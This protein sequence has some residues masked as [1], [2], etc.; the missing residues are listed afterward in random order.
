[1]PLLPEIMRRFSESPEQAASRLGLFLGIY[2]LMQFFAAPFFGA[3]SDIFGRRPILLL[4]SLGACL[5]YILQ[6]MSGEFWFL[7]LGR[8]VAGLTS[9]KMPLACSYLV[10][11]SRAEDRAAH[12]GGLGAAAAAGFTS[13]TFLAAWFGSWNVMA[14]F[15]AGA[16]VNLLTCGFIWFAMPESLSVKKPAAASISWSSLYPLGSLVKI[17]KPSPWSVFIWIYLLVLVVYQVVPANWALATQAKVGWS[18]QD[19]G[20]SLTILGATFALGQGLLPRLAMPRLGENRSLILGLGFLGISLTLVGFAS[21]SWMLY[22]SILIFSCSAHLIPTLQAALARRVAPEQQGE[23]QGALTML[24]RGAAAF[25]PWVYNQLFAFS[26]YGESGL[27]FSG[28]AFITAAAL[29]VMSMPLL[30]KIGR[31]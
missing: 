19:V 17:L 23:L 9:L 1:M 20:R 16:L 18:A 29:L 12:F 6:A 25:A 4:T 14:P 3:L 5:G 24:D 22:A 31:S 8:C 10:D 7:I 27:Q 2:S 30:L 11:V 21:Q 13:G 26:M 15:V 28:L